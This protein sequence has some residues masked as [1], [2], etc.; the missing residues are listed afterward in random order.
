MAD[1]VNTREL[2]RRGRGRGNDSD[3]RVIMAAA[4]RIDALEEENAYLRKT[5]DEVRQQVTS[6]I[7]AHTKGYRAGREQGRREALEDDLK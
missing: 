1:P 6:E 5:L 2:R 3:D 4:D 7:A